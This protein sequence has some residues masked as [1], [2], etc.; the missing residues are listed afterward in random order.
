MYTY[1]HTGCF[2]LLTDEHHPATRLVEMAQKLKICH[3]LASIP[4]KA[5][6]KHKKG[7]IVSIIITDILA[8]NIGKKIAH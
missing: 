7:R 8:G 5:E 2:I 4:S 1:T 3:T 6:S